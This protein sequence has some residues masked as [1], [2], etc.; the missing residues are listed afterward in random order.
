MKA[1]LL[2]CQQLGYE[3]EGKKLLSDI[4]FAVARGQKVALLGHNGAGKSTLI[5]LLTGAIRPSEGQVHWY[6]QAIGQ[7]NRHKVGVVFDELNAFLLLT[8]GEVIRYFSLIYGQ[9][10]HIRARHLIEL[11]DIEKN[12]KK[13]VRVLSKGE[14]KKLWLL[15]AVIHRPEFLIMDEAT[16]ELDPAIKNLAWER[17]ILEDPERSILFTTHSWEEAQRYAD[18]IVFLDNGK[19]T[20]D[21]LPTQQLLSSEFLPQKNK[22]VVMDHPQ[23]QDYLNNTAAV[24]YLDQGQLHI[25]PENLE[26]TLGQ[27]CRVTP[28]FSVVNTSLMDVYALSQQKQ[29]S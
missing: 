6:G 19:M 26:Q 14:R 12:L 20:M 22:V 5:D 2:R 3:T 16:A 17:I 7:L 18:S 27:I 1:E 9:K 24:Y 21:I 15:L 8:V 23:L 11:L 4:D 13:Q 10:D 25:L 28:N 29:A